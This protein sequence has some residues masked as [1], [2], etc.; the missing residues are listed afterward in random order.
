[1]K[2]PYEKIRNY[3]KLT[4]IYGCWPS[5]HDA[6]VVSA[7]L[8]RD[9]GRP[10]TGPNLTLTMH[11]FRLEV[12]PDDPRRDNTLVAFL[13]KGMNGLRLLDFNHQNSVIELAIA[14]HYSENLNTDVF[15]VHLKQGFG[16]DC[17]FECESIE[18]LSVE[19]FKPLWGVW[20]AKYG[21]NEGLQ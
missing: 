7:R 11:V 16:I 14:L 2:T 5:F 19:P 3:E 4:A 10:L 21:G 15:S 13:F 20:A 17:S 12:L 1:M 6:E 9:E 18:V 8:E